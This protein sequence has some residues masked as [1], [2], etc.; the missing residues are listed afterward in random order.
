MTV[1]IVIALL[2][3]LVLAFNSRVQLNLTQ[4]ENFR[5]SVQALRMARSASRGHRHSEGFRPELRFS[6]KHMGDE[7]PGT[8]AR[9]GHPD[10]RHRGRGW[11]NSRQ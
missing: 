6:E 8:V 7:F 3:P 11:Q 1:L 9:S 10:G 2:F 5:N 4:A